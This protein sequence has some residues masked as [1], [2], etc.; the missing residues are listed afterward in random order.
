MSVH[1]IQCGTQSPLG[2][3]TSMS[4]ANVRAGLARV[5]VHPEFEDSE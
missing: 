5:T 2:T 3:W 1:I 4:A